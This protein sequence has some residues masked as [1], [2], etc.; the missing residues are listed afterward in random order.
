MK[1]TVSIKRRKIVDFRV[2]GYLEY[3]RKGKLKEQWGSAFNGQRFRQELFH[4]LLQTFPLDAIVETGTYRGSSTEFMRA[5]SKLPIY[6]VESNPRYFGFAQMRFR[7]DG[8][9][10]LSLN[11]SRCFLQSLTEKEALREARLLFYLDSHWNEDLPL[12]E[13]I[14]TIFGSW[15]NAV[16]MIDDFQVPDD[17]GYQFDAYEN[18]NTI[19]LEY[20]QSSLKFP[21]ACFFPSSP[22]TDETGSKRGC[23]VLSCEVGVTA[24]LENVRRLRHWMGRPRAK[25]A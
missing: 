20:L 8:D 24:K 6:S 17:A 3:L 19:C 11:D 25:S 14:E 2:F 1:P 16:I 10:R 22:S 15:E 4:E 7:G 23:A 9:V 12:A 5:E 21:F 18:G 13:E